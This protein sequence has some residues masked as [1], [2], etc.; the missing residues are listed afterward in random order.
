MLLPDDEMT[1]GLEIMAKVKACFNVISKQFLDNIPQQIDTNFDQGLDEN[2]G[3][4]LTSLDITYD[5][6]AAW[7]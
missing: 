4:A 5:Q 6:C 3:M 7:L 1:P 2:M